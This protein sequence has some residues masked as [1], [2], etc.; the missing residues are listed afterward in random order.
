MS[1]TQVVTISVL[2]HRRHGYG[3]IKKRNPLSRVSCTPLYDGEWKFDEKC[4][5]GI[6]Y[7]RN[8]SYEGQWKRNCRNGLGTMIFDNG[9]RYIG[10]WKNGLY[11]GIGA[12]YGSDCDFVR[13]FSHRIFSDSL[14]QMRKP[15]NFIKVTFETVNDVV[16]ERFISLT[17]I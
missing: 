8:G 6:A 9:S 12:H 11:D 10:E 17:K 13:K 1:I 3:L 2:W 16:K 4:G 5:D 14:L 7:Y 15:I